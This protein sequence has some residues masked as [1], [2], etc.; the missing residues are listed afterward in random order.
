M[1]GLKILVRVQTFRRA[2]PWQGMNLTLWS[3][4]H[5]P[6]HPFIFMEVVEAGPG[7]GTVRMEAKTE[8]KEGEEITV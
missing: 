3:L 1:F 5:L 7:G 4:I 6:R 2:P 8:I